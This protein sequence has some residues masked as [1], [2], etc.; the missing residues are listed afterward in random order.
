MS[1]TAGLLAFLAILIAA[2]PAAAS[3][4]DE[5]NRG[6]I[7][8]VVVDTETGETLPG[9]TVRLL[10]AGRGRAADSVGRFSFADVPPRSYTLA[11]QHI[12]YAPAE[13][14]VRL[15][16]GDS[17]FVRITLRPSALEMPAVVI[18]GTGRERGAAETYRPTAVL[19]GTELQRQLESSLAGTIEHL[20][21]IAMQYNGPAA[22]QP[23]I[24]GLGGDRVLMLEDGQRTGD[25]VA[26]GADHAVMIDPVSAER[27]EVVRGP[28]GLLYGS[29]A[30][31]GVVNVVRH[32]IPRSHPDRLTG[33]FSASGESVMR[34]A[35]GHM[36]A[37]LP[38]G[39]FAV[40]AELTGRLTGD[41][42]T[43][44]GVMPRSNQESYAAGAGVSMIRPWG[45]VG[46]SYREQGFNYGV[47]GEFNGEL[48][49]GAHTG[50]V[51]IETHRRVG[52]AA[53]ALYTGLG[54]LRT[55][56]FDGVVNHYRHDEI[57]GVLAGRRIIG[58]SFDNLSGSLNLVARHEHENGTLRN[59]GAFGLFG[60][61]R[62]LIAGGS[63]TGTR[64]AREVGLAGYVYE[65]F[66]FDLFRVQAGLRYDW[67][68]VSP[69]DTR[70]IQIGDRVIPVGDRDFHAI[71]GSLAGIMEVADGLAGG[72]SLTRS[73]RSPAI[74]EL[75]SSGPHLADF[76]YDIGDPNL[77]TEIGYGADVF[78]RV[79]R[80]RLNAEF[81]TFFNR[82]HNF[83]YY[84]PTGDIDPRLGR[85]PVFQASADDADF[86]GAEGRVKWEFSRRLVADITAS[87]VRA[88]RLEEGDPLPNIPALSVRSMLRYETRRYF[89]TVSLRAS[90]DQ[91]RVPRA[92]ASPVEPGERIFPQRPTD[93][94]LLFDA[95]AGMRFFPG[96][97]VHT[98]SLHV[99]NL[100]NEVWR[101]HLSR[102]KDVAP[103]PGRN[104]RLTYRVQF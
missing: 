23:V 33:T 103:M 56:E 75:Y 17:V 44:L 91:E 84:R 49:P 55:L 81:A 71:S 73:F 27:I 28:A 47:P 98:V 4:P 66:G 70:P 89:S 39:T 65:E 22:S 51:D 58:T 96:A 99:A 83:I 32:E 43:P 35:A 90:A 94:Y 78:I 61:A 67:R 104:V 16:E 34:G 40:R 37:T 24:R 14:T 13:Q 36:N 50:G 82:I 69:R 102:V 95:G 11:V 93:G 46:A 68:R 19:S 92:I 42:R 54:P 15:A 29:N 30:L 9:A 1:R 80:Q 5:V 87:Y 20:P 79:D 97:S 60:T 21:G 38:V 62:D 86:L 8:G 41:V 48:I 57:E 100:T 72:I 53:G 2:T 77:E 3:P 12:G 85:F 31:G 7:S 10:E 59:E 25:L 6:T 45:F 64:S 88:T 26:T 74:E 76:S 101:D 52:R 18:T 63:Y